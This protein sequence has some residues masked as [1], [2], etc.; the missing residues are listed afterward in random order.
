MNRFAGLLLALLPSFLNVPLRRLLGQS[1]GRGSK[2]RFG[3]LLLV[4]SVNI[5]KGVSLGPLCFI[6]AEK[7][8]LG[9]HSR[10]KPLSYVSTR[11]ITFG[12]YVHSSPFV[13]ISG[14]FNEHSFL[15]VGDHS[16]IFPFCLLDTGEGIRVGKQTAVGTGT[17]IYT[18]GSWSD[19]LHGGPI[20]LGS[21]NIGDHVQI[22]TRVIILPNVEIG[23]YSIIGAGSFVNKAFGPN[24]LIAGSPAKVIKEV[25]HELN[26][27]EMRKRMNEILNAFAGYMAFHCKMKSEIQEGKLI[28]GSIKV[29]IDDAEG[30]EGGD[31]LLLLNKVIDKTE[32]AALIFKGVSILDYPITRITIGHKNKITSNLISFVRRYGIRLYID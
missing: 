10:I 29:A 19:Y 20:L 22:P 7:L 13:I 4:N 14:E 25:N 26:A 28:F 32:K 11:I 23:N 15:D 27:E 8:T 18:H 12:Q 31:I 9:D 24:L 16:R 17:Y 2:I 5:G 6:K 1:I 3:T 21:V 30:L